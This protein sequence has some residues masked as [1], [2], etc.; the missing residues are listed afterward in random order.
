MSLPGRIC[1]KIREVLKYPAL[2]WGARD[3]WILLW[4][5]LVRCRVWRLGPGSRR[6]CVARL[7]ATRGQRVRLQLGHGE[8]A[9]VFDELFINRVYDLGCVGFAPDLVVDCGAFCGYFSAMAAGFFPAARFACFEANPDNIPS[10]REQL[11]LLRPRVEMFAAAVSVRDGTAPFSGGG[12]G[13]ALVSEDSP[14]RT[15]RVQSM[16]FPRWLESQGARSL[17]WKLDVEGAELEL[18]PATLGCLPRATACFLETHYTDTVCKT[19]LD[20]YGAAG[21]AVREIRRKPSES[22]DYSYIEWQLT[23]NA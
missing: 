5:G 19:L 7:A 10:L 21:F 23:R 20:P 18:L 22:G 15:R 4:I 6:L 2:A 1:R 13:G 9:D 12:M 16:N 3:R 11:A 17:V 8:Q 14:G